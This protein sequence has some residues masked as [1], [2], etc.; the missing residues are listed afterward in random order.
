[1]KIW[2]LMGGM[3]AER[4]VSLHS[5][6]AVARTLA[7]GG[8]DVWAYD[9]RDGTFFDD[10]RTA[11]APRPDG[12]GSRVRA[13]DGA[14]W[15]ERLLATAEWV[16]GRN[17]DVAFLALHGD[18]GEDGTVQALLNSVDFTYTGSGPTAC[19]ISMDKCLTKAIME[20][21]GIPTPP[22]TTIPVSKVSPFPGAES[23]GATP[24]GGLPVVVKPIAQGSSV[25]ISIVDRPAEWEGALRDAA[26]VSGRQPDARVLVEK[27][28]AGRELTV[29]ILD[30]RVLP[31]VEIRP[32]GGFYD[33]E[34]KYRS[35]ETSYE[36]PARLHGIDAGRMQSRALDLY[37]TLG[38]R[39]VARV[40]F[41]MDP[42]GGD[43]C[44]EL[45]AIPGLTETSLIP[46]AAAVEGVDFLG[47][48]ETMCRSAMGAAG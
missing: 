16:R 20:S 8:H 21:R 40:D 32:R 37:R 36:V 14:G 19:A 43:F 27:Y 26:A 34:R 2:V 46:K 45:N 11:G 31:I 25:G 41:R 24:V 13:R 4:E 15:A 7:E 9:L 29:G 30:G 22:W 35:G 12:V 48:L 5:G 28:I 17:A 38:C 33:Y 18:E 3:S 44:L 47:L 6:R 39:G 42:E 10:L 23:L 1:M